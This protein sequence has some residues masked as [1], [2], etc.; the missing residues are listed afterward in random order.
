[1]LLNEGANV[2]E[3]NPETLDTALHFAISAKD[4]KS[5]DLLLEW[6]ADPNAQN[7]KQETPI[8]IASQFDNKDLFQSLITAGDQTQLSVL[9]TTRQKT[10]AM[11]M[12]SMVRQATKLN[13]DLIPEVLG[14]IQ[15]CTISESIAS[16]RQPI[17]LPKLEGYLEKLQPRSIMNNYQRR[18]IV[19]AGAY[20]LWSD[21]K[22]AISDN[23][24]RAERQKFK[25]S[26]HL[27]GIKRIAPVNTQNNNKFMVKAKD[28]KKGQMRE[29]IFR[30]PDDTT[31]DFWVDGLKEHK[32]QYE[33]L[34][35][36]LEK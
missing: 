20:I 24:S 17:N 13:V 15:T 2:N 31:R 30:C 29:Y 14:D 7:K 34:M 35:N 18:W 16:P 3:Q 22:R 9:Q 6:D 36:Y 25:G 32:A 21:K 11:H 26:I 5:I 12:S 10:N 33:T 1:L 19:V 8:S 4:D 23:G 27:M 28:A